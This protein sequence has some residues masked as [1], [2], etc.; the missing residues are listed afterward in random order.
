MVD[1]DTV[2]RGY[3]GA[4]AAFAARRSFDEEERAILERFLDAIPPDGSLLDAGCGD[5][6][7]ILRAIGERR[8]NSRRIGL[9]ISSRQ[10]ERA[11]EN[12]PDSGLVQGDFTRL[13][14]DESS[15]DGVLAFYSLIHVPEA[16]H[17]Q[18]I[19]EFS[20]VVRPGG[21]VL[22]VEGKEAW[23]GRNPDWLESSV[24]MQWHIAGAKRTR[25]DIRD[26]GFVILDERTVTDVLVEGE[27]WVFFDTALRE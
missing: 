7:P 15:M 24:E 14:L 4:A 19:A 1:K 13:P 27:E 26:A 25:Q 11:D 21:R 5:G 16:Q 12:L 22:I 23:E 18:A 2:R 17:P 3:D 10:L 8:P 6:R 9:D 20:R